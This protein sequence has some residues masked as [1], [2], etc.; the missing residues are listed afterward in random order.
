VHHFVE[1]NKM[2]VTTSYRV[3]RQEPS[4]DANDPNLQKFLTA[5]IGCALWS[6]NTDEDESLMSHTVSKE[7]QTQMEADCK[8]FLEKNEALIGDRVGDAGHD[9]WL[10]RNGHGAGFWDGDWPEHGEELTEASKA[11]KECDLYVGD[12]D[13]VYLS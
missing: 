4:M 13:L 5:Y 2:I 11:F 9:F 8:A 6:S 3:E 7:A 1:V 12:D 10:T